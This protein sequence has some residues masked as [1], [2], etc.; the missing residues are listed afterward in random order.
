M[1]RILHVTDVYRPQVAGI[2]LFVEELADQQRK[3]GHDV[4]VLTS[5]RG[6]ADH[7]E[8]VIR[9]SVAGL[10]RAVDLREYDVVHAH[11]SV[12]STATTFVTRAAVRAGVP[13]IATVH[14]IWSSAGG[15][16]VPLAAT[17]GGWRRAP[18]VW[19]A[20]SAAAA[21]DVQRILPRAEVR[22]VPNAVD[23]DWWRAGMPAEGEQKQGPLKIAAVMRL[24][25]RKRP[26]QLIAAIDRVRQSAPGCDFRLVIAGD[27]PQ[28]EHCE[29][30]IA[31]HHLEGVV[32][33]LGSRTREQV[34]DLYA[35]SDIYVAPA[36]LESFGIAALEARSVGLPVV[37]MKAGGVG[38][39]LVEGVDGFL[40]ADDHDLADTLAEL[41]RDDALRTRMTAHNRTTPPVHDWA[42]AVDN[43]DAAY[44]R[45][46]ELAERPLST[47]VGA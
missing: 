3:Q 24:A 31:R 40:C 35:D 27:G 33:L 30:A 46:G 36:T 44:C 6:V 16:W 4:T 13:V 15:R 38:E 34:R 32:E 12:F 43:Y 14:S 19:T 1:T 17:L 20:V 29:Q 41:L 8:H 9:G 22:V 23:V 26:L 37:G 47:R 45:A 10:W 21:R 2:E 7:E 25:R 42:H 5:A 39:F 11:L 18:I 28:R